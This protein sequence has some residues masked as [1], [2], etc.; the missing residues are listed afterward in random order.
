KLLG[1]QLRILRK[2]PF[3]NP[4]AKIH[5]KFW[6][7]KRL[8]WT[9]SDWRKSVWLDEAKM[10][11]VGYQPGRKVQIQPGEEL[12]DKNLSTGFKF[13]SIGVGFWAAIVYG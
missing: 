5:H 10:Q 1:F 4:L 12:I 3:L 2:K 6:S 9:K 7:R 11:Y 13:G 8:R